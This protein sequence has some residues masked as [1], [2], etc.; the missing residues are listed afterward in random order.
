VTTPTRRVLVTGSS[1]GIGLE[2]VRQYL[3]TGYEVIATCRDPSDAAGLRALH[4]AL[5]IERLDVSSENDVEAL[6]A[7]LRG[8]TLDLLICNAA[9]FGGARSRFETLDLNMWRSTLEVNL[10]GAIRVAM[11][12]WKNVAESNERKIVFLSSR[13]GL[14]RE[15]RSD[16]SYIYASSKAALNAAVRCFAL[17]LRE[18]GVIVAL[19]NPGHVNTRIGGAGAPMRAD[20]SVAK[21]R[22]VIANLALSQAG[23][24]WHFDGTELPL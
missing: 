12:L 2:F 19:L 17:D 20:E 11:R 15:A 1:R 9:V 4:G 18:R 13:A 21:M 14:P 23:R 8:T 7:D 3:G 5:R 6:T 16:M 22:E 10:L 24:F